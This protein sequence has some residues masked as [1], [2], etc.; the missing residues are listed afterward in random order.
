MNTVVLS[1][2]ADVLRD[3]G[4]GKMV[5]IVDHVDRE[6][7]GD[8]C[9]ATEH[10]TQETLQFMADHG[11]G[12]ICVS[13]DTAV[14]QK[15][16]LPFQ[17]QN[18]NSPFNT[19]FTVTVDH[20]SVTHR[21]VLPQSRALTMRA[22]LEEN[23]EPEDFVSPGH[24][25][26]L[27]AH[28]AGV[29]GRQ[30]QTEGSYDLARLAGCKPS[31]VICEI[32]HPDGTMLRGEALF[33]FAKKHNLTVTSV[34]EII[35]HRVRDEVLVREVAQSSLE[36]DFGR[37]RTYVFQDDVDSKEHL[38][39]V[40]GDIKKRIPLVRVHSECLTGDVF[41]SLR[42]DC[43]EQLEYAA[44]TIVK[45][46]SGII[47]YL[48]QEGRG[49]GLTNKLKA[50]ALQD[51]GLDTVEANESL[52]FAADERDFKVAGSILDALGVS[53]IRILTNNPDKVE[54]LKQSG[55]EVVERVPLVVPATEHSKAY[56]ETKRSKLGHIFQ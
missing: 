32:L 19:P 27:I 17:V 54:T 3:Y 2:F 4:S 42:C 34:S 7:E 10:V 9:V 15:L 5:I 22:L 45:E 18:N 44:K 43:G 8:L 24:V 25:F 47:L 29:I 28:P 11:R 26:P 23:A 31:G 52:G 55:I 12:L 21:G 14:A 36:T 6:N 48:R 20:K 53:K 33:E 37:F 56:L 35:R 40:Y 41:G 13:V 50:Y 46:G 1:P 51:S 38:A 30:G 49:I 16:N 39:L